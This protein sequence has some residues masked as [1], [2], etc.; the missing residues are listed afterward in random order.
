VDRELIS[1]ILPK[2]KRIYKY[3]SK[4]NLV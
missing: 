2:K 1:V 3:K 4:L